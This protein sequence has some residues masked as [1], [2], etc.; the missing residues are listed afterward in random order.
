V[1]FDEEGGILKLNRDWRWEDQEQAVLSACSSLISVVD[2]PGSRIVQFSRFSVKE[3]LTLAENRPVTSIG[4]VP[5]Y[6]RI[7]SA[8]ATLAQACLAIMILFDLDERVN[9][10]NLSR[11]H[12]AGYSAEYWITVQLGNVPW[13]CIR[14][15]SNAHTEWVGTSLSPKEA[16]LSIVDPSA[17]HRQ[18]LLADALDTAQW[19]LLHG[20]DV[21][22]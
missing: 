19:L 3:C 15:S 7:E 9:G 18:R 17:W 13:P 12:L 11:I 2:Y 5:R 21:N 22:A 4:E 6:H 20:A 1:E 10:F 16:A 8:R 14:P